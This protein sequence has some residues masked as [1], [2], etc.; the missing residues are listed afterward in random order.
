MLAKVLAQEM[1]DRE[2]PGQA[3]IAVFSNLWHWPRGS[4]LA[5]K[6]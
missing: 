3:S 5:V 1:L 6:R 4:L 2:N